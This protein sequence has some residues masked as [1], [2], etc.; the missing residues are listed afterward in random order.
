MSGNLRLAFQTT[1]FYIRA[2]QS[3]RHTW[4]GGLVL[5][6]YL[7]GLLHP[8]FPY[9][10]YALNQHYIARVLCEN[11]ERPQANCEGK[12]YLAQRLAQAGQEAGGQPGTV[13][14]K[15]NPEKDTLHLCTASRVQLTRPAITGLLAGH[16]GV[17]SLLSPPG[18]IFHPPR[19]RA[20]LL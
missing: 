13:P 16:A 5:C 11:K 17:P 14:V 12:C 1:G 10:E 19:Q 2:M 4:L 9:W 7:A 20:I 3:T 15:A 18:E 6:G 8:F